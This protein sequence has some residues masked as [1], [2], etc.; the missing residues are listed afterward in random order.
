MQLRLV[1]ADIITQN[2][3]GVRRP[4]EVTSTPVYALANPR[5]LLSGAIATPDVADPTVY[6]QVTSDGLWER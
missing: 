3:T 5:A 6:A 1:A 4:A 2:A